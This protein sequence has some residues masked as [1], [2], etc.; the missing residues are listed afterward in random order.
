MLFRSPALAIFICDW[1]LRADSDLSILESYPEPVQ[2]IHI[3]CS[4]RID[5]EM[6]LKALGRG[7]DGVLVCGCK[8]GECHYMRG[9]SISYCKMNLLGHMFGQM[10][11]NQSAVKF[12]QIGTQDRGRIRH[13]INAMLDAISTRE[14]N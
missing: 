5:P 3:P 12:V 11:L 4:G 2:V 1:C 6:A 14:V 9:T 8:P 10:H 7:Y 13:E